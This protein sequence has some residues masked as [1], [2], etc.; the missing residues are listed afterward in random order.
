MTTVS[1]VSSTV[2]SL[3]TTTNST[4]SLGKDDFLTLLVAQLENQDPLNPQE[5][6]EFIAQLAQFSALEQQMTTN[7]LLEGLKTYAAGLESM[8]A[9]SMLGQTVVAEAESFELALGGEV[10]LGFRLDETADEV[11]I[12]IYNAASSLVKTLTVEDFG[13]GD[14]FVTWDGTDRSGNTLAAGDYTFEVIAKND[15]ATL[16]DVTELVRTEVTG[17]DLSGDAAVLV[18]ASGEISL[19]QVALINRQAQ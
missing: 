12:N 6:A 5:G 10:E 8:N 2:S 19:D 18:T 7:E 15:G 4:T 3:Y 13:T 14:N 9:L 16:D 11:T 17:V 1:D